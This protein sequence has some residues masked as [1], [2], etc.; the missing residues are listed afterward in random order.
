VD[1]V[2]NRKEIYIMDKM[3]WIINDNNCSCNQDRECEC[4]KGVI[5]GECGYCSNPE[6][7]NSYESHMKYIMK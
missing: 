3:T 5:C 6:C 4:G 2:Y 1:F 7:E